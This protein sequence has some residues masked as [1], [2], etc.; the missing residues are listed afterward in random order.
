V[1]TDNSN[2]PELLIADELM[3][4]GS[5]PGSDVVNSQGNSVLHM[6]AVKNHA[7]STEQV[8]SEPFLIED[9]ETGVEHNADEERSIT[10]VEASVEVTVIDSEVTIVEERLKDAAQS[11]FMATEEPAAQVAQVN[12]GKESNAEMEQD[13]GDAVDGQEKSAAVLS[14]LGNTNM[15]TEQVG[16]GLSP[17]EGAIAEE[18]SH[19]AQERS[20][21]EDDI[22]SRSV[23]A[24]GDSDKEAVN[25]VAG[26]DSEELVFES[27]TENSTIIDSAAVGSYG[28]RLTRPSIFLICFI[29]FSAMA[30]LLFGHLRFQGT[31]EISNEAY[32]EEAVPDYQLDSISSQV[33]SSYISSSDSILVM[34]SILEQE[35]IAIVVSQ[36]A[37]AADSPEDCI[38]SKEDAPDVSLSAVNLEYLKEQRNRQRIEFMEVIAAL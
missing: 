18:V 27:A 11:D 2:E 7:I 29:V 8:G 34:E 1:S 19:A 32:A 10:F 26:V 28:K 22:A 25:E 9:V 30:L 17:F 23:S 16:D 4:E 13:D 21:V 36:D 37:F 38:E 33:D 35:N 15:S 5:Q 12:V 24:K 3:A 31:S 6:S 20:F 14:V